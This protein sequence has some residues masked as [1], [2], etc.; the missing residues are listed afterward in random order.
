VANKILVAR[1]TK[2]RIE[3]I[4]STLT[5]NELVYSTDTGELGVKK[6]NG[7]IE[8]F[9]N[10]VDI[11]ASKQDKLIAG[12]NISIVGNT[13]SASVAWQDVENKPELY[14][15]TEINTILGNKVDKVSGMGLSSNDFTTT[16]KN[17]LAGIASGA[18]VNVQSDW[19]AT[20]G[21]ALIL[22]KPSI[23]TKVSDLTND[24][25]YITGYTETDPIF[26][27]WNKSTGISITK[28][29]VSDLIEATQALSGL[30]SAT[31]K[32][33]L[34]VLHALLE[35]DEENNV[36][37]SI[38]EVLAIFNNYPEGADLVTALAGKVDKVSGKGLS[39]N[40][41]TNTLKTNYDNAYTHSQSTH[42]P[43]NAQKNS[44]ITKAEIE[45]KLTG[46]ISSHSHALPT[47]NHD[48]RYYTESEVDT[49]LV[50]K[51]NAT[52]THT[53]SEITDFPTSMPPTAHNH[54]DRYYT[55]TEVDTKLVGK[56]NATHNH[57]TDYYKKSE[58]NL[59]LGDIE[60][61]LDAI[62]GV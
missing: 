16:E 58:I 37:D 52:H 50:G 5:V 41:L 24:T 48:D 10:A 27:A 60:S 18:E 28:S 42:A 22:N 8:Y 7:N 51:A 32:T 1:G 6:A 61:A 19:D 53:K 9:M 56:A 20:S 59:M 55:E 15:K 36:V 47:H 13:I 31:D 3:E 57:D 21:D 33:R 45:A 34:D 49:K 29:Q 12:D 38:N 39:T 11:D 2:A 43:S 4:K 40:D 30:M 46:E 26:K 14:N 35:E 54:D 62:L 23:P 44:D 17:K 25:G